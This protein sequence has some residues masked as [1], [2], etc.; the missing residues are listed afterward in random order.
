MTSCFNDCVNQYITLLHKLLIPLKFLLPSSS[1][2]AVVFINFAS[3]VIEN[4]FVH[5]LDM[6]HISFEIVSIV[7][8]SQ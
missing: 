3:N 5:M 4:S 1:K 7:E 8:K 2:V 6:D